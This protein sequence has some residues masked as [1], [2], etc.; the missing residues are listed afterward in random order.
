MVISYD[1]KSGIPTRHRAFSCD[2]LEAWT[3]FQFRGWLVRKTTL[4]PG[5][6]LHANVGAFAKLPDATRVF[7][8]NFAPGVL[9][10]IRFHGKEVVLALRDAGMRMA[11]V[12]LAVPCGELKSPLEG[13]PLADGSTIQ[14]EREL[15][16]DLALSRHAHWMAMR[17]QS[18]LSP[19]NELHQ[20]RNHKAHKR[21]IRERPEPAWDADIISV[22]GDCYALA[23]FTEESFHTLLEAAADSPLQLKVYG[24]AL[25]TEFRTSW[26]RH[27]VDYADGWR[28][29]VRRLKPPEGALGTEE[30]LFAH[31]RAEA[32]LDCLRLYG[33]EAMARLKVVGSQLLSV[34][35]SA[36]AVKE[37]D[38]PAGV[39]LLDGSLAAIERG[40]LDDLADEHRLIFEQ[41]L[42][43]YA[44]YPFRRVRALSERGSAPSLDRDRARVYG[45]AVALAGLTE[46]Q[47]HEL[48]SAT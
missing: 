3:L 30:L 8:R 29:R 11:E 40:L 6:R 32:L 45:L 5:G 1:V 16:V 41:L 35:A 2:F 24:E 10:I 20:D 34:G 7:V 9:D 46:S 19:F 42:A 47:W 27:F 25:S 48:C 28:W 12:G 36:S 38:P 39:L 43:R 37:F 13:V 22:Y 33:M 17:E 14:F 4:E 18:W 31:D 15:L 23:Q 44:E 21:F 26:A